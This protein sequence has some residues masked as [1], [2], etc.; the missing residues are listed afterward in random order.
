[1]FFRLVSASSSIS[2]IEERGDLGDL[3]LMRFHIAVAWVVYVLY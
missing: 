3:L 2:G 1:M